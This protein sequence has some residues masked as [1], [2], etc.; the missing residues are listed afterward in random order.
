M[1]RKILNTALVATIM[2]SANPAYAQPYQEHP[3]YDMYSYY[4]YEDLQLVGVGHD[5]CTKFGEVVQGEMEWGYVTNQFDVAFA[6][7]CHLPWAPPES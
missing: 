1:K 6:G 2:G 4:Y 3:Y 5:R 7:V